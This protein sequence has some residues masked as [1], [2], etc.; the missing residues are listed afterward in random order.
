MGLL[1][2]SIAVVILLV[3]FIAFG[4]ITDLADKREERKASTAPITLGGIYSIKWSE[5]YRIA[6]VVA[7]GD[8]VIHLRIYKNDFLPRPRNI[9]PDDLE[10]GAKIEDV[11]AGK[12]FKLGIGHLPIREPGFRAASPVLIEKKDVTEEELEG[13]RSWKASGD[14][15]WDEFPTIRL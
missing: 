2:V 3:S 14:A 15:A 10:I 5:G 6:K 8:G 11:A 4:I 1:I 12:P 9:G 13:Y 7:H